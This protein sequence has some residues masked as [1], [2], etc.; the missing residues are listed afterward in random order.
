MKK[1]QTLFIKVAFLLFFGLMMNTVLTAQTDS[2]DNKEKKENVVSE[3]KNS[4]SSEK[5]KTDSG[6]KNKGDEESDKKFPEISELTIQIISICFFLVMLLLIILFF[7]SKAKSDNPYF[8]FHSI[9]FI[10]L[11]LIFPGICILAL[12]SDQLINGSTLAALFG[13][14]AGYVL[15]RDKEDDSGS[16]ALKA[17]HKQE[18]QKLSEQISIL[19]AEIEQLKK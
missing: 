19:K 18:K 14:I 12:I 2:I 11:I 10:G 16:S 15:S 17:K 6:A 3:N 13:T 8:G 5:G 4:S 7:R 9:K 1:L